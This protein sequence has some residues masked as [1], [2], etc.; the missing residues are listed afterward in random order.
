MAGKGTIGKI[1]FAFIGLIVGIVI[2][3]GGTFFLL[4][5][6]NSN[7]DADHVAPSV[8]FDRMTAQDEL[9]CASQQYNITDKATNSATFFDICD[10]PFTENSFWY[11]F[12]GTIKVG[13]DLENAEFSATGSTIK[14][15]LDQPYIISNT[16]DMDKSGVLEENNNFLNPIKVENI[17]EFQRQCIEQSENEIS[18]G[19]IYDEAR[20]N[21]ERNIRDMFEAA[22][23]DGYNVEFTWR[24]T[25]PTSE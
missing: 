1:K 20:A 5:S 8:V 9:V 22:L 7:N 2:G 23:G 21:A 14:V 6:G 19:G 17:D 4:Q 16:P 13:V 18:A 10:I 12:V 15:E 24:E 25:E 11:R 3:V